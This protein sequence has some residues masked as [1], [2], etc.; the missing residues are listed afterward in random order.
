MRYLMRPD[1]AQVALG[2]H[3][4][5][6]DR[7]FALVQEYATKPQDQ[8]L[9]EAH[10]RYID[11][12]FVQSGLEAMGWAPIEQMSVSQK[13]DADN[14]AALFKGAGQLLQ[15]PAGSFAIFL[16]HDVHMPCVAAGN[17]QAVRKIVIKVAV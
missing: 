16:P 14:D 3:S 13:Y 15:F 1:L 2:K 12:Q 6:G 9:W 4:I 7:V 11:V 5:D 8:C 17:P 10:R